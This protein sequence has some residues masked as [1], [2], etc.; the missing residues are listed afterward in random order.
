MKKVHCLFTYENEVKL[1]PG[2]ITSTNL[3]CEPLV[4]EFTDANLPIMT[5]VFTVTA[6]ENS[7]PLDNPQNIKGL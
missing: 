3:I 2:K 5:A 6:G 7:Q 1:A 4:F